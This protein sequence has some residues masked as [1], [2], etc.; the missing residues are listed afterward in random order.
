MW[1]EM[2]FFFL[3]FHL[4]QFFSW[5]ETRFVSIPRLAEVCY[6]PIPRIS[7]RKRKDMPLYIEKQKRTE[8]SQDQLATWASVFI[9]HRYL[10]N[11]SERRGG[12]RRSSRRLQ[13]DFFFFPY[14][15]MYFFSQVVFI[16]FGLEFPSYSQPR[17]AKKTILTFTCPGF[18]TLREVISRLVL[19]SRDA[20]FKNVAVSLM[21]A[22]GNQPGVE[23]AQTGKGLESVP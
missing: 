15:Y 17:L 19:F 10:H 14:V 18:M 5:Y 8:F 9:S 2:T 21:R 3:F 22:Q 7:R 4:F 16:V 23:T 13:A 1:A 12:E 20:A 11:S 6:S